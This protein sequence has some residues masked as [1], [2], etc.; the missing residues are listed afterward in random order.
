MVCSEWAEA[1]GEAR[2]WRSFPLVVGVSTEEALTTRLTRT[3]ALP[4]LHHLQHLEVG[5]AR[6]CR[7]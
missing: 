6:R 4:R 5:G 3:L 1:A 2:L 7:G